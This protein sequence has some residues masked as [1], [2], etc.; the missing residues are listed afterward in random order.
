MP[1]RHRPGLGDPVRT[2]ADDEASALF[3]E[4]MDLVSTTGAARRLLNAYKKGE[5]AAVRDERS[6]SKHPCCA[7]RLRQKVVLREENPVGRVKATMP[8]GNCPSNDII[9][10]NF[11]AQS[12]GFFRARLRKRARRRL[13]PE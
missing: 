13:S 3:T 8:L 4:G 12:C 9:E 1:Y 11:L 7:F 6:P 10:S 2:W 5:A